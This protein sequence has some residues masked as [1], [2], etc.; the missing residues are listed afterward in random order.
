M[1]YSVCLPCSCQILSEMLP[2]INTIETCYFLKL[3][4]HSQI[5]GFSDIHVSG[6]GCVASFQMSI[7][8]AMQVLLSPFAK[9]FHYLYRLSDL[10]LEINEG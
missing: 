5:I 10:S 3:L 1:A 2:V 8:P 6:G 9:H 7:P 4:I